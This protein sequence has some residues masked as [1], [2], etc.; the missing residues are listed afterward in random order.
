MATRIALRLSE[1]MFLML[2]E[3]MLQIAIAPEGKLTGNVY[4]I[5]ASG[6]VLAACMMCVPLYLTPKICL[7]RP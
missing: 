4:A 2:G 6:F 5:L 3:T 1:F 7:S